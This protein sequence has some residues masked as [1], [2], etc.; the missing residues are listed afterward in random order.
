MAIQIKPGTKYPFTVSTNIVDNRTVDQNY[1]ADWCSTHIGKMD[2]TWTIGWD[3]VNGMV[4][5]FI[6]KTDA[7]FFNL[8]WGARL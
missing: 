7:G 6:D 1:I 2:S 8:A 4:Y 5:E 3:D